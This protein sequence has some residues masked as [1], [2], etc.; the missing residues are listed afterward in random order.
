DR[1]AD[2]GRATAAR[3][4][5]AFVEVDLADPGAA[6]GAVDTAIAALDGIDVLVNV[7]GVLLLKPLLE[8]TAAEWDAVMAV[9]ARAT[10]ATMQAAARVMIDAGTAGRIVNVASMAAETG[11]ANEGAYAA[12]K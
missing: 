7:A 1:L 6:E 2:A 5:A 11:G 3:L 10:L 8:T 9:N 4:D 12:S